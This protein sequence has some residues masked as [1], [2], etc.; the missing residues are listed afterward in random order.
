[1]RVSLTHATTGQ[2]AGTIKAIERREN[3]RAREEGLRTIY[4]DIRF[5]GADRG[6]RT[7]VG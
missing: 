4:C 1:M 7:A 6:H 2:A 3:K 5:D